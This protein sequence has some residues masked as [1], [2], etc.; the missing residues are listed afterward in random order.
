[1]DYSNTAKTTGYMLTNRRSSLGRVRAKVEEVLCV[2][3]PLPSIFNPFCRFALSRS[4]LCISFLF[5]LSSFYYSVFAAHHP[6]SFLWRA[7]SLRVA[8][9]T[10]SIPLLVFSVSVN[11]ELFSGVVLHQIDSV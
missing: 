8:V 4:F 5:T 6:L 11:V 2:P 10:L 7:G 3:C 9:L 1:M